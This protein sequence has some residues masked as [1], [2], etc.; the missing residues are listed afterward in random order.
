M[1]FCCSFKVLETSHN[2]NQ[3]IFF[4]LQHKCMH[5]CMYRGLYV[6]T[7]MHIFGYM[8]VCMCVCVC[9]C[10]TTVIYFQQMPNPRQMP[11]NAL[12]FASQNGNP[13]QYSCLENPRDG[14]AW[15]AA[16]YGVAQSR[17]R[18]K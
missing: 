13:L 7:V 11:N 2:V 18:L 10:Q 4:N 17:T 3:V 16:I 1:D 14:G 9:L 5:I 15:W 12:L 8:Y 6:T